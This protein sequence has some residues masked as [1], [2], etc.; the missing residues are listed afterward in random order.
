[1]S[2]DHS[3]A[4]VFSL[5]LCQMLFQELGIQAV[6][7]SQSLDSG[8]KIDTASS[9]SKSMKSCYLLMG[10]LSVSFTKGIEN[11]IPSGEFTEAGC[12]NLRIGCKVLF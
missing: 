11:V 7:Y 1:M 4:S 3:L 10:L 12:T 2:Q 9:N 8:N 6:K 5:T